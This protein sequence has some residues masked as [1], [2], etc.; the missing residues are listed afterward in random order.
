MGRG[1]RS[2]TVRR[3]SGKCSLCLGLLVRIP[4]VHYALQLLS[5]RKPPAA[6]KG[7]LP[8]HIHY[9]RGVPSPLALPR[10]PRKRVKHLVIPLGRV[11]PKWP[12]PV[13]CLLMSTEMNGATLGSRPSSLP[14]VSEV[15][16]SLPTSTT[17]HFVQA[18]QVGFAANWYRHCSFVGSFLDAPIPRRPL[19]RLSVVDGIPHTR[20]FFYPSG[21]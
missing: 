21:S 10:K 11:V 5:F 4:Q 8:Q 20:R 6:C 13:K 17:C 18:K 1:S 14:F 12:P 3:S 7:T 19:S 15:A 16:S 9:W 2:S